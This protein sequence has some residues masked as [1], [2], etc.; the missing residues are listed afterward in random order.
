LDAPV[1]AGVTHHPRFASLR[2]AAARSA[3]SMVVKMPKAV[4]P[5]PDIRANRHSG[6]AR[7]AF[8]AAPACFD[9]AAAGSSRSF[10]A[11][12]SQKMTSSSEPGGELQQRRLAGVGRSQGCG[13]AGEI[14]VGDECLEPR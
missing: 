2:R 12:R 5:E 1:I 13:R 14:V 7:S 6:S 9:T 11:F 8:A 4:A 3:A 10:R